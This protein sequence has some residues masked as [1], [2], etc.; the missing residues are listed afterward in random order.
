MAAKNDY[1]VRTADDCAHV[2]RHTGQ[3]WIDIG[4]F[5]LDGD[6][7]RAAGLLAATEAS[8]RDALI[9]RCAQ[10]LHAD[11]PTC[12]GTGTVVQHTGHP[13][14]DEHLECEDMEHARHAAFV[15]IGEV[16]RA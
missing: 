9:E 6:A 10:A 11:C 1:A 12:K 2:M 15:V 13:G 3:A 14:A 8:R 16:T 5:V 7:Q 4:S